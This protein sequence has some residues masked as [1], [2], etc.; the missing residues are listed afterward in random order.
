MG[1]SPFQTVGPYFD[2]FLRKRVP[3]WMVT[4]ETRGQR[5][6]IDG[7]LYD[8]AG[9][10]IPD[11]LVE[12]WQADADGRY[13][14]P[15]DPSGASADPS[16][17]GYGWRHTDAAGAFHFD[18]IKPGPIAALPASPGGGGQQAPHIMV[19]V[20]G[21]GIL[22]RFITRLYFDDEAANAQDGVLQLVP[23]ARRHTLV[24][25]TTSPGVYQF[26]IR[27]QGAG[28]TVFFDA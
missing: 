21:R 24:A 18:T 4:P 27:L 3:R 10:V 6:F 8:G 15:D 22:T 1:V 17:Y 2:I 5:I 13:A 26:D 28:E 20:M 25:R 14:H 11:G 19:S 16:F 12:I 7:V 9:M 23:D